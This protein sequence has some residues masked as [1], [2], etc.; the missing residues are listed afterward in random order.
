M[1]N[2]RVILLVIFVV[3]TAITLVIAYLPEI[4]KGEI[5][6]YGKNSNPNPCAYYR[7]LPFIG[8]KVLE[9]FENHLGLITF[10]IAT[11]TL[12]LVTDARGKE[13]RELRAY[14]GVHIHEVRNVDA[15]DGKTR[16]QGVVTI[17]NGGQT[18]AF[19][20]R[21]S[22]L[23]DTGDEHKTN[24]PV[25]PQSGKIQLLPGSTW[26]FR[27]VFW[28]TSP[29]EMNRVVSNTRHAFVW[30]V[31]TYEDI[32]GETHH[33]HFRLISR[34][35]TGDGPI[36]TGLGLHPTEDGNEAT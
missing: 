22:L 31:V 11:F 21:R 24:F 9:I 27:Q 16:F 17:K 20:V 15:G 32:Y 18:P 5:C 35:R 28:D 6:D 33:T 3:F 4:V 23:V 1:K 25:A 30:G 14:I 19:G 7:P 8:I 10:F 36:V 2:R 34:E 26:E 12:I 13:R 29:E